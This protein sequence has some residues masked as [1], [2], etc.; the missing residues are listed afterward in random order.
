[1]EGTFSYETLM[2]LKRKLDNLSAPTPD[3]KNPLPSTFLGVPIRTSSAF[4]AIND[5]MDCNGTG[6][7]ETS[8]YCQKC[9]GAGRI[10]ID[11]MMTKGNPLKG[12][13]TMLLRRELP[14]AFKPSFPRGIV[15]LPPL[16]RGLA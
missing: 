1:M 9:D 10:Q 6:E 16:A 3:Y 13:E 14:K 12:G 7:G 4:P 2:A 8:T 15:A 5:C 11:G